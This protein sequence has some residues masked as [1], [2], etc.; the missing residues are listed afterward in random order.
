MMALPT[1]PNHP[2]THPPHPHRTR[3]PT[4]TKSPRSST[5]KPK[6]SPSNPAA[7]TRPTAAAAAEEEEEERR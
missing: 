2:P 7:K 5:Y 4:T 3:S 1:H 6:G